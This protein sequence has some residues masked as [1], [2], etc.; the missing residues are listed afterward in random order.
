MPGKIY[1]GIAGWSYKDWEGIVYP[2][3]LHGAQ[4]LA[5]LAEFF[6]LVEINSSF[7]GPIK[8]SMGEHWCR[9][10][11]TVNPK[12]LFTAKLYR[13]FTHSPISVVESTSAKTIQAT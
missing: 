5:Y 7:Y 3:T 2:E 9:A 1:V 4:R 13:A 8:P 10:V 12:F 11:E 6:D